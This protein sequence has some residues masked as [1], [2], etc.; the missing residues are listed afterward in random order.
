MGINITVK[1]HYEGDEYYIAELPTPD[2]DNGD[3]WFFTE[4]KDTD[5]WCEDTFGV[6]DLWGEEPV[7]GWKRMRNLY[8]FVDEEQL[9]WFITRWK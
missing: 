1:T 2:Y 5:R 4:F 6:Q 7:T 3:P 8:F 9:T